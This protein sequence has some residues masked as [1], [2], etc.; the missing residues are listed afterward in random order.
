LYFF[1]S[2]TSAVF[3]D[4]TQKNKGVLTYTFDTPISPSSCETSFLSV[5][6]ENVYGVSIHIAFCQCVALTPILHRWGILLQSHFIKNGKWKVDPFTSPFSISRG[7]SS[8]RDKQ[9]ALRGH[10]IVFLSSGKMLFEN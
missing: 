2:S 1:I 5:T 3:C 6:S 4:V 10:S 9:E 8:P 7:T